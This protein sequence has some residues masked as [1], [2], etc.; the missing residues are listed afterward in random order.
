MNGSDV[1]LCYLTFMPIQQRSA[2][3]QFMV[4]AA[5]EHFCSDLRLLTYKCDCCTLCFFF[6]FR[7]SAHHR[8]LLE[9]SIGGCARVLRIIRMAFM[10]LWPAGQ[11]RHHQHHQHHR[12]AFDREY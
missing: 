3:Y 5:Y 11:R 1:R 10:W 7:Q 4:A 6:L 9:P 12:V 2:V 8:R